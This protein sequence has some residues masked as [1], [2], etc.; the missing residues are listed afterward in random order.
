MGLLD[1]KMSIDK[2]SLWTCIMEERLIDAMLPHA[3]YS[4]KFGKQR[5]GKI[6]E[7]YDS[8]RGESTKD[9]P[10]LTKQQMQNKWTQLQ[11]QYHEFDKLVKDR[12]GSSGFGWDINE[13]SLTVPAEVLQDFLSSHPEAKKF[14][15]QGT[16]RLCFKWYGKLNELLSDRKATGEFASSSAG[17]SSSSNTKRVS[18]FHSMQMIHHLY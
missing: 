4:P 7:A 14:M 18:L 8:D 12:G 16:S 1:C 15:V 9:D 5:W 11:N 10:S 2:G 17:H 6:L 3:I 13:Q